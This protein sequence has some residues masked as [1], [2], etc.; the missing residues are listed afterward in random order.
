MAQ[1]YVKVLSED[2]WFG[3]WAP[4]QAMP[5]NVAANVFILGDNNLS[6]DDEYEFFIPGTWVRI[7]QFTDHA[8]EV[9][10]GAIEQVPAGKLAEEVTARE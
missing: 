6:E 4:V 5:S 2:H 9:F 7:Q 3:A 10:L 8:G 1:I